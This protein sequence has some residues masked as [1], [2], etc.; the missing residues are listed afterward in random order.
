MVAK[1][2]NIVVNMGGNWKME[3]SR[4]GD[5]LQVAEANL[6]LTSLVKIQDLVVYLHCL[7]TQA[8]FE[9]G[10]LKSPNSEHKKPKKVS[11]EFSRMVNIHAKRYSLRFLY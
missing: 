11:S 8:N 9:V 5:S 4:V 2:H 1:V 6:S 3:L 7:A 10:V